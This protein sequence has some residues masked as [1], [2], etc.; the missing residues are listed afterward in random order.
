LGYLNLR[1]EDYENDW[2]GT[3]MSGNEL[4]DSV[5]TYMVTPES[6]KYIYD[7]AD[8]SKYIAHGFVHIIRNK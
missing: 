3:D 4:A 6:I 8:R 1:N 7:D 5:Y 2:N